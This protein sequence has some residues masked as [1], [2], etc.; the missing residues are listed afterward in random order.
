VPTHRNGFRPIAIAALIASSASLP[1]ALAAD[2]AVLAAAPAAIDTV[3]AAPAAGM[4]TL[5]GLDSG[6]TFVA[7]FNPKEIAIDK[8]VPWT[9]APTSSGDRPELQFRQALGRT[10]SFTLEFDTS[11]DGTDVHSAYV[12]RLVALA[13]VMDSSASAPEDKRRPM[14]VKVVDGAGA[15]AFEGVI[16]SIETR[17]TMFLPDGT[18]VQATC[19]VKLKEASRAT[20]VKN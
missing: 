1:P 9:Q 18:P 14:R 15:I 7:Q 10:M 17:Y 4:F 20:F 5:V 6:A 2:R 16:E 19:A 12:T 3:P 13:M 8:S 11:A